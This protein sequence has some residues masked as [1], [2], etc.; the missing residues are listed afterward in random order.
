MVEVSLAHNSVHIE[1]INGDHSQL[2]INWLFSNITDVLV[3]FLLVNWKWNTVGK[4]SKRIENEKSFPFL[5][6]E[7]ANFLHL[8]FFM[9]FFNS[10]QSKYDG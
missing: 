5:G 8:S 1:F 6:L 3:G 2:Y 9:A 10:D 7:K 4:S